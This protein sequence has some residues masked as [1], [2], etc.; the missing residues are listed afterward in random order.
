MNKNS[1]CK[2]YALFRFF[3]L[4]VFLSAGLGAAAQNRERISISLH[5]VPVKEVVRTIE[6]QTNYVFLNKDV[7]VE[8]I[9]SVDLDNETI[10]NALRALFD[11][12]Q[13][14]YKIE[15]KHIILSRRADA[16]A[17]QPRTVTGKVLDSRGEPVIGAAV[18]VR[19]TTIGTGTD[20]DGNFSLRV[21]PPRGIGGSRC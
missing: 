16:A 3:L 7:D 17:A 1:F 4:L 8:R 5:D 21:P 14:D 6:R 18:V 15:A 12:Q 19:G 13:V 9:V 20:V 10:E 2:I 11:L